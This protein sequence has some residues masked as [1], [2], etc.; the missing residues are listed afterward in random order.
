MATEHIDSES[1]N[2]P[3]RKTVRMSK[4]DALNFWGFGHCQGNRGIGEAMADIYDVD[5]I[6]DDLPD[7]TEQK[8][9]AQSKKKA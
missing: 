9:K 1:V 2:P 7:V 8:D 3:K 4:K 6:F 5:I